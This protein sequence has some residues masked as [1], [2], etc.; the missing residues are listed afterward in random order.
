[1]EMC[2][3][4]WAIPI[5]SFPLTCLQM[6]KSSILLIPVIF[7]LSGCGNMLKTMVAHHRLNPAA[8]QQLAQANAATNF[9]LAHAK[10]D[11]GLAFAFSNAAAQY[12]DLTV[13][14]SQD[15]KRQYDAVWNRA[16]AEGVSDTAGLQSMCN[17]LE[18]NLPRMTNNLHERYAEVAQSLSV[19]RSIENQQMAQTLSGFGK[20]LPQPTPVAY[21]FPQVSYT[22]QQPTAQNVLVNTKSGL[23]QCRVTSANFVFCI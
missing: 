12:L 21:S 13:S 3:Y 15:Y 8:V 1:M 4:C 17:S 14:D 16:S 10:V 2:H 11:K 23:V 22:S 18:S 19:A 20:N 7:L 9:C 6:K 5:K